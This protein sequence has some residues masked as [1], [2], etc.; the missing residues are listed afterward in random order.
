M[1]QIDMDRNEQDSFK[2]ILSEYEEENQT[3]ELALEKAQGL[4]KK[5]NDECERTIKDLKKYEAEVVT[6]KKENRSYEK[7]CLEAKK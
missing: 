7:A 1:D 3:K 5:L 6:L 2:Q 4:I